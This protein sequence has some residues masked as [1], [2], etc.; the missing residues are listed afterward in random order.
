M[1]VKSYCLRIRDVC[2][3]FKKGRLELNPPYQRRPAWKHSQRRELLISI[4]NGIPI[5]AVIL[6]RV[7]GARG[8][9]R[10]EVM[11]GKQRIETILHF[12]Y[13]KVIRIKKRAVTMDRKLNKRA[14]ESLFRFSRE[15][16]KVDRQV[17]K[18]LPSRL[19][20]EDRNYAKYIISTREGTDQ[21]RNRESREV[22]LRAVVEPI[23]GKRRS[24]RRAFDLGV[25][26]DLWL[27]SKPYGGKIR[28]P[29]PGDNPNCHGRV[30]FSECEVDHRVAHVRGGPTDLSNAQLLC[31]SCNRRKGA[32]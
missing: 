3:S 23:F 20:Q 8:V 21:F 10:L 31:R 6:Y 4:F 19:S 28:C 5:P 18:Y 24:S 22:V 26:Q 1:R 2:R 30:A 9:T 25:K 13:G 14:R 15:V 17:K 11:D 16:N 12:R 27:R 32:R 29:N 7:K